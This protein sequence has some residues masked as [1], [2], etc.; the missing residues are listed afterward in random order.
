[1]SLRIRR[2]LSTDL[3][4]PVEGELLYTT[5]NGNLYVGFLD[6]STNTVVPRLTSG[7][8]INDANPTLAANLDL[9]GN[10]ILG[11]G[12]INIDGTITATGNI[13]LGDGF[14]DNVIVGGQIGSDLIPNTDDA[15]DL[16]T[17][18]VRWRNG[19]F[20]GLEVD[21]EIS[22]GSLLVTNISTP[23]STSIYSGAEGEL[24]VPVVTA[25]SINA[26]SINGD[27]KGS[28]FGDDSSLLVDAVS[29]SFF[30]SSIEISDSS[31]RRIDS[32]FELTFEG[33]SLAVQYY[34]VDSDLASA[35]RFLWKAGR[36]NGDIIAPVQTNDTV[37]A[38]IG[39][40]FDGSAEVPNSAIS[41]V[42][43]EKTGT[44]DYPS[45]Y[46]LE[47]ANPE[48]EL[49]DALTVNST[50]T[51]SANIFKT[52]TYSNESERDASI[53]T[54][55]AGMIIFLSGHD[56]STGTPKFQGYD[57]NSWIDFS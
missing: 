57:G 19:Y 25:D 20:Q 53:P 31:I 54:P 55:E 4:T 38:I 3:P 48:G 7:Q 21:G 24:S 2:G 12:D 49:F 45:R 41:I 35:P 14:E 30:T 9:N 13:N 50:G 32:G 15:Y 22:A 39:T 29:N 6:P 37:G 34:E 28:I 51:A 44:Y 52:G 43:D 8:L 56:D 40:I 23:D 17:Q 10:N 16:G 18:N 33:K 11:T 27:I 47:L 26:A 36:N 46:N 42:I 5:D 1:M